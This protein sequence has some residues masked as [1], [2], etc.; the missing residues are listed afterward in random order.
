MKI[1]VKLI[2]FLTLPLLISFSNNSQ[3]P[4]DCKIMHEGEFKYSNGE[5]DVR[6]EIEGKDHIEWHNQGKYFIKSKLDWVSD[7]EYNMTMVEITLPN[8]PFGP[9]DV[10]NVKINKVKKNEIFYTSTVKGTSWKGK[11]IK[12]K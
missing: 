5:E 8:F 9:G 6:V 1:A 3:A 11:F 10:M 7:C 4:D 2:L 12:I